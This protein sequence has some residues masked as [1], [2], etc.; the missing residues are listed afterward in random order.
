MKKLLIITIWFPILLLTLIGSLT[1]F[2]YRHELLNNMDSFKEPLKKITQLN[3]NY[4][5][6]A[7][8]PKI[9]GASAANIETEDAVP[10]RI[11]NY[12][13]KYDSPMLGSENSLIEVCREHKIDPY[14]LVAIAQCE[15]NL[16]K[17]MPPDCHNPF[18]WGIHSEGTLCFNSWEEGYR[19][20]VKGLKEN[21]ASVLDSPE[22]M[23]EIYTPPSLE[24]GGPWAK[25]VK[26]FLN[27]LK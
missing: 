2:T 11:R 19:K 14:L 27:D 9:M 4:K 8:L 23:M 13:E 18:G 20:V 22:E 10:V 6:Y 7:S 15:S 12:F 25:C 21:Y 24:K 5:M 16:G 1:F 3:E 17:K 26:Q